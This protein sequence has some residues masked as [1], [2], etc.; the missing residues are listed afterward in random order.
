M[1]PNFNI[2]GGGLEAQE[3][4]TV[5]QACEIMP[6]AEAVAEAGPVFEAGTEVAQGLE[7]GKSREEIMVERQAKLLALRERLKVT[8]LTPDQRTAKLNNETN[9]L[10]EGMTT[11]GFPLLVGMTEEVKYDDPDLRTDP[12]R[13]VGGRVDIDAFAD[14]IEGFSAESINV[15]KGSVKIIRDR[16]AGMVENVSIGQTSAEV[17]LDL[18]ARESAKQSEQ[19][20]FLE[21][22]KF[23]KN[24]FYTLLSSE[25]D[26]M[27]N[28]VDLFSIDKNGNPL[29][30]FDV[31]IQRTEIQTNTK[32]KQEELARLN[33]EGQGTT[34]QFGLLC[35]TNE[36]S[37]GKPNIIKKKIFDVPLLKISWSPGPLEK[38]SDAF[39]MYEKDKNGNETNIVKKTADEQRYMDFILA[40]LYIQID[41]IRRRREEYIQLHGGMPNESYDKKLN[42]FELLLKKVQPKEGFKTYEVKLAQRQAL[43][44]R[45]RRRRNKKADPRKRGH[46]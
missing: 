11:K 15:N 17:N 12:P 39:E 18:I 20:S 21:L 2:P 7:A 34:V 30:A 23:F 5:D 6:N 16:I 38:I 22:N 27:K 9:K 4:S 43:L 14:E 31:S 45:A 37:N 44:D 1:A 36:D 10:A 19:I 24:Y 28:H 3:E 33:I 26:D 29:V 8:E 25:Y 32:E 35:E 42:D 46:N 40:D 13:F 41:D